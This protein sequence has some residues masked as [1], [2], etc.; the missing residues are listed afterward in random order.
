MDI[1]KNSRLLALSASAGSGK[2]FALTVRYLA[3]LFAG[4]KPSEILAVTFTNKAANEM[5]ERIVSSLRELKPE[6]LKEIAYQTGK[7]EQEILKDVPKIYKRFLSSDIS[8][9][10]IDGFIKKILDR[11][12]WYASIP[13]HYIVDKLDESIFFEHFI[14][15][16]SQKDYFELIDLAKNEADTA[17][18]VESF[19]NLLYI[20]DKELPSIE[21]NKVSRYDINNIISIANKISS[22]F[23]NSQISPRAKKTMMFETIEEL[24]ATKWIWKDSLNYWDY[25]KVFTPQLDEYLAQLHKELAHYF[26]AK[27][28]YFL[29]RIFRLYSEYKDSR[30]S[31]LIQNA[32]LH[33][34]DIEHFVFDLIQRGDFMHFVQFRLD[35]KFRHILFDEFQDTSVTQYKIFEPFIEEIASSD[36][37][38]TFFYVGDTKQSIYRFRGGRKELFDYVIDKFHIKK[39]YLPTNY[40]SAKV[41]VD[42]VND[43]FDYINPKQKAIK[44]GGYV[45]I[46]EAQ[47]EDILQYTANIIK[48]LNHNGIDDSDIAILVHDNKEILKVAEYLKERLN[49]DADTHKRSLVRTQKSAK[50][51][52]SAIKMIYAKR[53]QRDIS[54][55]R[56]EILSLLGKKYNK[57]FDISIPD[58]FRVSKIIKELMDS[59]GLYDE[60]AMK[61]LEF[62]IPIDSIDDFVYKIDR[63]EEELPSKSVGGV[64]ILTI[65]KSKGLEFEHLIVLDR[66]GRTRSDST[67]VIFDYDG[68]EL[69]AL[70]MRFKNREEVDEDYKTV[71]D[72]EKNLTKEDIK[73]RNY[74]AFTRAKESLH[75]I[76]KDKNSSFE[77]LG[78]KPISIGTLTQKTPKIAP[79]PPQPI[80]I[81][82]IDYGRQNPKESEEKEFK[83]DDLPAIYFGN[84]VHYIFE[85]ECFEA[86]RNRYGIY[87]DI[88]RAIQMAKNGMGNSQYKELCSGELLKELAFIKDGNVGVIDLLV[89]KESEYI[90]IDYKTATPHDMRGYIKQINNY[91]EAIST[92]YPEC[93]VKGYLYFLDTMRIVEV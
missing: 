45:E 52:I 57:E 42:F 86:S 36:D 21:Y 82:I 76:K 5:E 89:K 80:S 32:S 14:T 24:L 91:K 2:T 92:F 65:H 17:S 1:Q 88:N 16:L 73:N 59:F 23:L 33:F 3:L 53:E 4:A 75:I 30:I 26:R 66:L 60:A 74:V 18:S 77:A 9:M 87:C 10:T 55:Y 37:D 61:L 64:Q 6:M 28:R 22:Y 83:A 58:T 72:K 68:I 34:I 25:K 85:T 29:N 27:E 81:D 62:S 51:I 47:S 13:P 31:K 38:R 19:F 7:N 79:T 48:S 20:K 63:Y 39:E 44:D 50:I 84:A 11:F 41:I 46:V 43:T 90:I 40:R 8:I 56:L 15:R 71:L 93:V 35:A 70:R 12:C 54:I 49:K 78:L 69:K 67:P